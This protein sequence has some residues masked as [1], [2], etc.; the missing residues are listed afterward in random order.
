MKRGAESWIYLAIVGLCLV[1]GLLALQMEQWK[2]RL[3]PVLLSS[4]VLL[5]ALAGLCK[6]YLA[7]SRGG[8]PA[9]ARSGELGGYLV[10]GAWVFGF[11]VLVYF[12][13]FLPGIIV[14][15]FSYAK[16]HGAS[17]ARALLLAVSV[18]LSVYLVFEV[19]L[20]VKLYGGL[21]AP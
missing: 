18:S 14:Y 15:C 4:A 1:F 8:A 6:E 11:V 17:W 3:L 13:G 5:L 16:V 7:A 10:S 2:A 20:G 19:L 12:G 21:G 9:S